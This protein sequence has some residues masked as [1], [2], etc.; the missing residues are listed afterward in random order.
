MSK[1]EKGNPGGPGRPRGS[2]NAVNLMLDEVAEEGV[3]AIVRKVMAAATEGDMQAARLV[4]GR[5]WTAPKGR[6]L[7]VELPAIDTPDDLLA[8]HGAVAAAVSDGRLTAAEGASLSTML[9]TH[10]RAFELVAQE[11]TIDNLDSRVREYR[12]ELKEIKDMK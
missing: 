5:A 9:E 7:Q 6:P 8:A 10:R 11:R 1:F 12:D 2:R 3:A 4:L